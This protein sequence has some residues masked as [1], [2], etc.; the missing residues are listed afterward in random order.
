ME[1]RQHHHH[2]SSPAN[3]VA[4]W[5]LALSATLHCL[6][7]CGIGEV[8]GMVIGM[9]LLLSNVV[10]IVLTIALGFI[11]GFALGIMPLLRAGFSFRRAFKQVL[12]AEGLSIAVMEGVEVLVSVNIPGVIEAHVT[13]PMFWGGMALGL[14]AGFV[15]AY[16]VNYFFVS[17]GI[18]HQH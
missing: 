18:R 10:T 8:V 17:K 12:I 4:N 2:A 7:G 3:G 15:A 16:P 9:M 5:R 11:F 6:L 14:A 13:E 1:K